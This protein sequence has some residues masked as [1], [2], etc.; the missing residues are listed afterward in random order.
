MMAGALK[1]KLAAAVPLLRGN[2]H[3]W[4]L[5]REAHRRGESFTISAIHGQSNGARRSTVQ[6]FVLRLESAG[7]AE[8]TGET[9]PGKHRGRVPL[10][11]LTAAPSA[12]PI[13]TQDGRIVAGLA[14]QQMWNVMRGP[15]S[16]GGFTAQDLVTY[17]S[18]EEVPVRLS[19]ARNFVHRLSAAGYLKQLD[20]GGPG[21][22]A[23][24]RLKPSMNTGPRSPSM[25]TAPLVFDRNREEIVGDVIA[26]EE[27]A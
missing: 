22:L 7:I 17:G 19:T 2:D 4:K 5:M 11:R 14:Q 8:K 23:L 13:V 27:H 9:A 18:T 24:W 25:M 1:L 16:R 12:T 6:N 26:E 10:Y 21:R 20:R 3:Y 15:L